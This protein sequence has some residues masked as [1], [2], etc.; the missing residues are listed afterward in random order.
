MGHFHHQSQ[1][2][3]SDNKDTSNQQL[4]DS[5]KAKSIH[6]PSPG[7]ELFFWKDYTSFVPQAL[8][9]EVS[10]AVEIIFL[11]LDSTIDCC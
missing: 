4:D 2:K 7:T 8:S 10:L 6:T 3:D 9:V 5:F 11:V 1:S